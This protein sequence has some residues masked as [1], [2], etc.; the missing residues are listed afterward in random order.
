VARAAD[1]DI[2]DVNALAAEGTRLAGRDVVKE[3]GTVGRACEGP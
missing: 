1:G 3:A 2:D